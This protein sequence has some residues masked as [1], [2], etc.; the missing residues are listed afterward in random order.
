MHYDKQKPHTILKEK[1]K[2]F[3]ATNC[4][5][6]FFCMSPKFHSLT[7]AQI[8]SNLPEGGNEYIYM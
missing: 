7:S 8:A 3:V 1:T 5:A 4:N 6:D 2:Q